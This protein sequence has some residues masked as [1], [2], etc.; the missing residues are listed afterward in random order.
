MICTNICTTDKMVSFVVHM[1]MCSSGK[2]AMIRATQA[3]NG[4]MH[5][6]QGRAMLVACHIVQGIDDASPAAHH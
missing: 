4:R 2:F 6:Q 3:L 1:C 5:L